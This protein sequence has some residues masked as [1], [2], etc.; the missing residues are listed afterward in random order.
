MASRES[1]GSI[2]KMRSTRWQA[3]FM[4]DGRR[5]Y[6]P[7]TFAQKG[8]ARAWLQSASGKIARNEPLTPE[9]EE[10]SEHATLAEVADEFLTVRKLKDSTRRLYRSQLDRLI[11]PTLGAIP[12]DELDRR[13]VK[14]WHRAMPEA[15]ATQRAHCYSL[16]K[17]IMAWAIAEEDYGVASN[18]CTT[19]GAG[20]SP[21]RAKPQQLVTLEMIQSTDILAKLT[22]GLPDR[23][24]D[25]D[26]HW[27]GRSADEVGLPERLALM[28]LLGIWT[29][30]RYGEATELRR[31]DIDLKAGVIHVSRG[32]VWV[33]GTG[34]KPGEFVVGTPKSKA[35]VRDVMIP[36]QLRPALVEHLGNYF[37]GEDALLF[38][39]ASDPARHLQQATFNKQWRR[40][41]AAAGLPGL[42]YHDLRHSHLTMYGRLPGVTL[43]ELERQAGHTPGSGASTIYQHTTDDHQAAVGRSLS[44][45]KVSGIP[46]NVSANG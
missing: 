32:V 41:A 28:P 35:G 36:A 44:A 10:V 15:T 46:D 20:Q 42:S 39:S 2:V 40:V 23:P 25:A 26:G 11:L 27:V 16:L 31:K 8:E 19:R 17:S 4:L 3:S 38:P 43:A 13:T 6:A 7:V 5:Q 1:F 22:I 30:L 24:R 45:V 12:V 34:G 29:G 37:G 14:R 21:E 18:P 9:P 33:R